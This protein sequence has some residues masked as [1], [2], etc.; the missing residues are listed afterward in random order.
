MGRQRTAT[1]LLEA[2]GAFKANPNRARPNEPEV[3]DPINTTPPK[4]LGEQEI[5]CWHEV[6][7][8]VPDG[9]LKSSDYVSVELIAVL[10]ADFR[11]NKAE[12]KSANINR[13]AQE[14]TKIGMN[15]SGRAALSVDKPKE[16]QFKK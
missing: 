6:I 3:K 4:H 9:V 15:P 14:I 7:S 16:N 8:L 1:S 13:L 10:L 12:T 11:L 5:A 2:R